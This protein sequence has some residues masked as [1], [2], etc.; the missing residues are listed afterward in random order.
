[1]DTPDTH[2][3]SRF[4]PGFEFLQNLARQAAGSVAPGMTSGVTGMPPLSQWVAPSFNPEEL[5]RR[6]AELRAVHFWLDQN[7]KALAATIQALEVQKMTLTALKGMNVSLQDVAEAFKIRPEQVRPMADPAPEPASKPEPSPFTG[8]APAS[9]PGAEEPG[10][11]AVDPMR[12]WSAL[13]EQFQTIAAGAVQDMA[14]HAAKAAEQVAQTVQAGAA[15]AG[16]GTA[17]TQA[18]SQS[19]ASRKSPSSASRAAGKAA[20]ARKAPAKKTRGGTSA[21]GRS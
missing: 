10:A 17:G 2:A 4:I 6:I 21:G 9:G 7:A 1:M 18:K 16:Q 19:A 5:E 15:A 11:P 12:W 3:F 14:G 20:P 8:A 13:T